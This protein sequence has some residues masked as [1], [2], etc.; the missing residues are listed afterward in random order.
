[1]KRVILLLI[2]GLVSA[3]FVN[4]ESWQYDLAPLPSMKEAQ[5]KYARQ[6]VDVPQKKWHNDL[7]SLFLKHQANI[8]EINIRTFFAIDDNGNGIIEHE[9]GELSGDFI[10]A[11]MGVRELF[12]LGINTVHVLPITA[13]GKTHALGNAGSLYALN[14]FTELNPQLVS[15]QLKEVSALEQF[16]LFVNECHKYNIR[17]VVDLP[18]C[19]SY[20]YYMK[21]PG[22]FEIGKNGQPISPADWSDVLLFKVKNANGGLNEELYNLHKEFVDMMLSAGVDGIRADVATI[23]P[24]EFWQR[25]ISY[26]RSKDPQFLFLAEAS[27]S[28]TS[29]PSPQ[30]VFTPYDKLLEAGFDGY[31]GSYFNFKNLKNADD[32]ANIVNFDIKL[33][34]KYN[35]QKATIGSFMTHDETSP[36][37]EGGVEYV[38]QLIWLNALLPVNSYIVDG[39]TTGDAFLYDYANMPATTTYTD[40]NTYYVHKGK[41][42]IFNF[43]RT[44][45]GKRFEIL[46]EF[47]KA[48][49]FKASPMSLGFVNNANFKAQKSPNPNV[50]VF[51]RCNGNDSLLIILNKDLH[52]AQSAKLKIKGV[53]EDSTV[54]PLRFVS[55][56]KKTKNGLDVSLQP[57]ELQIFYL[58]GIK[59]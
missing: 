36:I 15:S 7:R 19:G 59:L 13:I 40:C 35:G 23:K 58:P 26:T 54:V 34:Q 28:W 9:F 2:L 24:F 53:N 8:M 49:K 12:Y 45:G 52:V 22:L 30:A 50:W 56:S 1:M 51:S 33:S 11:M 20:D 43:S 47:R 31:Y 4:A 37:L 6:D 42:D 18:S 41:L 57:S 39:I 55:E 17:V 27:D 44:P 46:E 5:R 16:K 38:N 14:S 21:N 25:L 10:S 48:N 29:A 3:Q 32:F